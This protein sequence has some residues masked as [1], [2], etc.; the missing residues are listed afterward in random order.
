MLAGPL[1]SQYRPGP[2]LVL[3]AACVYAPQFTPLYVG[4]APF[5]NDTNPPV[6]GGYVDPVSQHNTMWCHHIAAVLQLLLFIIDFLAS[7]VTLVH[8]N[9]WVG[10]SGW[11]PDTCLPVCLPGQLHQATNL[12]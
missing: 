7:T 3:D 10:M 6:G 2:E 5:Y 9:T 8:A 4:I 11:S 12:H 1:S